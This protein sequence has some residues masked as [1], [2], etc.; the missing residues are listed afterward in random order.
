MSTKRKHSP[1]EPVWRILLD[2]ASGLRSVLDA[3]QAVTQR[4]IFK[5]SRTEGDRYVLMFDG[6]DPGM[7]CCV[8]ARLNVDQVVLRGDATQ[9]T[10]E[11]Q[12]CVDCRHLQVALDTPSCSHGS[13]LIEY[14][15]DATI[16]CRMQDPEQMSHSDEAVLNTYVE[17]E[18]PIRLNDLDST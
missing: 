12:F 5:V 9:D 17:S 11:F 13:L 4:V 1:A 10:E 6:A 2:D 3:V 15:D 14:H 18:N 7:T 16:H 8:S